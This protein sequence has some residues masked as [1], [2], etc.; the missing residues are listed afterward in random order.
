MN[1]TIKQ[2][3]LLGMFL[4]SAP[5]ALGAAITNGNFGASGACNLA[6]WDVD[7]LDGD[8][9][10]VDSGSCSANL[11]VDDDLYLSQISQELSFDNDTNYILSVD[12]NFGA[13]LND[14]IFD[15]FFAIDLINADGD[16]FELFEWDILG[17]ESITK[18][19]TF[20]TNELT[21]YA[22]QNW[23]LSFTLFDEFWDDGDDTNSSFVS[24]NNVFLE[25]VVTDVPEPSSL[26]IFALGFAGLISRRKIA[27]E[28]V[29]KSI[30]K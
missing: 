8:I 7:D 1:K 25:E 19:I 17:S 16:Y 11:S 26:A 28:L 23:S 2:I 4:V 14:D 15:D 27:N 12:F 20:N 29:R 9:S 10:V 22:D 5:Q 3:A 24:I 13:T 18:L 30:K 21:T 6:S